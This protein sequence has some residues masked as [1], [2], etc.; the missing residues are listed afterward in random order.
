MTWGGHDQ[1]GEA[2]AAA[3]R[4]LEAALRPFGARPHWGKLFGATF[5]S[6]ASADLASISELYAPGRRLERFKALC[7][8][9]DPSGKLRRAPWVRRVLGPF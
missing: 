3:S 5:E 4:Q 7:A 9:H 8:E 1:H 6:A 2:A